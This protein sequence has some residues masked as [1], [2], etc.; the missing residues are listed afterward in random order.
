VIMVTGANYRDTSQALTNGAFAY[1]PKP[2]DFRYVDHLVT[3]AIEQKPAFRPS[4]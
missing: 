2:F 1:L 3:L 4:S